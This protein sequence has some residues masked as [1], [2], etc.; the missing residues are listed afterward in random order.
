MLPTPV[1]IRVPG[2]ARPTLSKFWLP[3]QISVTSLDSLFFYQR[4]IAKKKCA[5][6]TVICWTLRLMC[7]D[8]S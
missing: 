4:Y 7:T 2:R 5:R 3:C 1:T 6:A 8:W